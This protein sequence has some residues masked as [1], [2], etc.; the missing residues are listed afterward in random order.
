M[1]KNRVG[2]QVGKMFILINLF[3]NYVFFAKVRN[4]YNH[5]LTLIRDKIKA[6]QL[7]ISPL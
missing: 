3:M 7:C 1:S 5:Y 6:Y 4:K 2:F